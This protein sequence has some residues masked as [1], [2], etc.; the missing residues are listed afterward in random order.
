M[1]IYHVRRGRGRPLLLLHGLGDSWRVWTPILDGLAAE[2]TV[3]AVDLPGFGET[4]P[5]PGEVSIRTLADAVTGF[6][7][8]NDLIGVDVVGSS[9]GA[10][11]VLELARRG[12]LVG[13][14]V[15]LD[16]GGF[17]RGWQRGYFYTSIKLSVQLIRLLQPAMPLFTGNP[18]GRTLLFPQFSAH[19]WTLSPEVTLTEMR[20]FAVSQ[21]T[22][23]LLHS[24]AFGE[25]QQGIPAGVLK[26]PLAI[27]WGDRD[28]VCF[29]GQA[30]LA[31]KLFPDAKLRWFHN[32]GHFPQWDAPEQTVR[33]ILDT[34][35][36]A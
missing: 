28:R 4:P 32:C 23:E 10:R 24:L 22:D 36:E 19:P 26:K 31:K 8:A 3:I 34:T 7:R 21:S 14:V 1:E 29:P 33:L 11:L 6:L 35:A 16:P 30:R 15:S 17:W 13:A 5:L 20:S 2:R 9:M 27:G 12:G 18:I 25:S